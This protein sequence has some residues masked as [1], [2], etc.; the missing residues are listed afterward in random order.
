MVEADV[1]GDESDEVLAD[2]GSLG[3]WL[4][5]WVGGSWTQISPGNAE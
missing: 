3:M 5:K 1:D 2:F 4:W